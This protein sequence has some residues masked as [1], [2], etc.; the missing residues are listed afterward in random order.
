VKETDWHS[1]A[2]HMEHTLTEEEVNQLAAQL[3]HPHFDPHG[4]PIPT[5]LGNQP[6]GREKTLTEYDT[7]KRLRVIHVEDEPESTYA[8]LVRHGFRPGLIMSVVETTPSHFVVD[9]NGLE[10]TLSRQMAANLT[11]VPEEKR[12]AAEPRPA[13]TLADVHTGQTATVKRILPGC[14][15]QQRRRL[16]DLGVLPGTR[17]SAELESPLGDPTAYR[18]R[19]AAIALRRDQARMIEI[20]LN[21]TQ[22]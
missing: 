2:E 13:A 3:G 11:V 16:M 15:G 6:M 10:I 20:E 12:E 4:D 17:I 5:E 21:D 8:D 19:G 22:V 1:K 7:G 14:R 9:V 18:I